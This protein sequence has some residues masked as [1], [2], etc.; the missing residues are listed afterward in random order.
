MAQQ[1]KEFTCNEGNAGDA[2]SIP[3]LGRSP[4]RRE[5]QSTPVFLP[6]ESHGQRSLTATVHRVAQ[7][8]TRQKRLSMHIY[9][10]NGSINNG[11][12]QTFFACSE[13]APSLCRFKLGPFCHYLTGRGGWRHR[14]QPG[15]PSGHSSMGCRWVG[16]RVE[17]MACEDGGR[18]LGCLDLGTGRLRTLRPD[19]RCGCHKHFQTPEHPSC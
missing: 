9:R 2:S 12:E 5:W 15:F 17:S 16:M 11:A 7:S 1:L 6:G 8:Q 10:A 18:P 14:P 13:L 4:G 19:E 3:G